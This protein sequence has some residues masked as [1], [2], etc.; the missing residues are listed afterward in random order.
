[1]ENK[2]ILLVRVSTERQDYD[3][4][5]RVIYNQAIGDGYTDENIIAIKEKE[6]GIQLSEEERQGLNRMKQAIE[7]DSSINCVYAWEI[8]RIAR[9]KKILFS[10]LEYLTQRKIQLKINDPSIT[11]LN[12]DGTVNEASE[13]VFTLFAQIAESEMRNKK[14]RFKRGKSANAKQGRYNGGL[15]KYGYCVDSEGNYIINEDEASLIRTIFNMYVYERLSHSQILNELKETGKLEQTKQ[16]QFITKILNSVEYTGE[17]NKYGFERKYP[18]IIDKYTFEKSREIATQNKSE[19]DKTKNLYLCKALI[20]CKCGSRYTANSL[21]LQYICYNRFHKKC[22]FSNDININIADSVAWYCAKIQQMKLNSE[23]VKQLVGKYKENIQLLNEKIDVLKQ[24][25]KGLNGK[26]ERNA[27]MYFNASINQEKFKSNERLI[28]EE[29]NEYTSKINQLNAEI[30]DYNRMIEAS[31]ESVNYRNIVKDVNRM[32]DNLKYQIIHN[33]IKRIE[34]ETIRS[35]VLKQLQIT[36]KD[37]RLFTYL[38]DVRAKKL[39]KKCDDFELDMQKALNPN[40]E[41]IYDDFV[42]EEGFKFIERVKLSE[43]KLEKKRELVRKIRKE[44][45]L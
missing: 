31:E 7:A 10:I 20:F 29:F 11:L 28:N 24:K 19:A 23:N 18:I 36:L 14:A 26:R 42:Q 4:Q 6:S 27:D 44:K 17:A 43:E 5:E 3:E 38:V 13:T 1:M 34:V 37:D 40:V 33:F 39:Y 45:S 32:N 8:S 22:D 41:V 2:C 35:R 30:T 12:A 16:K 15:I 9:K 21:S 25:I